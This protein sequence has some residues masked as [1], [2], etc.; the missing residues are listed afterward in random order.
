MTRF[1]RAKGSKSC[2]SRVEE[3]ATDWIEFK[4]QLEQKQN[5]NS[6]IDETVK[7]ALKKIKTQSQAQSQSEVGWADFGETTCNELSSTKKLKKLTKLASDVNK[8]V[9]VAPK[10][11]KAEKEEESKHKPSLVTTESLTDGDSVASIK[12]NRKKRNF[13]DNCHEEKII[14]PITPE[15]FP[16]NLSKEKRRDCAPTQGD[17]VRPFKRRKPYVESSTV[18][19]NGVTI[20]ISKFDGFDV[21]TED[22]HRLKELRSKMLKEGIPRAEVDKIMKLERRKAE[23]ALAREKKKVYLNLKKNILILSSYEFMRYKSH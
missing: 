9:H 1:A 21:K 19:I 7:K 17:E 10:N 4:K 13:V 8:D 12:K 16:T 14:H 22:A 11:T 18:N 3:D 5:H 2:N 15:T 6:M 23:K 20:N